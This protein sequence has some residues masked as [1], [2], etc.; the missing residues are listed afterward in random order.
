MKDCAYL[1]NF[2]VNQYM[3]H[4]NIPKNLQLVMDSCKYC[5][6]IVNNAGEGLCASESLVTIILDLVVCVNRENRDAP[7]SINSTIKSQALQCTRVNKGREAGSTN[8]GSPI[9]NV[10]Q[11]HGSVLLCHLNLVP[12]LPMLTS[13]DSF[14]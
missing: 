3:L 7:S 5:Q 1:H 4:S 13:V 12:K 10:L 6:S 11:S 2:L 14:F 9:I 8:K